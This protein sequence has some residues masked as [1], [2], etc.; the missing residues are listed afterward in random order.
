MK[1]KPDDEM[2]RP[3]P[4][5]EMFR[6][7]PEPPKF[8]AAAVCLIYFRTIGWIIWKVIMILANWTP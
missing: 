2:F 4:D 3:R 8:I 5:D 1:V 6:P 7:R